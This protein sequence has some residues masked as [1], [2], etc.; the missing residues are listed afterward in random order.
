MALCVNIIGET[1]NDF[2]M[3]MRLF[4][5]IMKKIHMSSKNYEK[6]NTTL[7]WICRTCS[8]N[9]VVHI[10]GEVSEENLRS[11]CLA[12]EPNRALTWMYC[13]C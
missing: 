6:V 12:W 9:R 4:T 7:M 11:M 8:T 5:L 3:R 1:Y 10:L 2:L 13:R